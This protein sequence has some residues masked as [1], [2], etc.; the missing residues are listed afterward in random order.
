VKETKMC[1]SRCYKD[2]SNHV[3]AYA[4]SGVCDCGGFIQ[5]TPHFKALT[6]H[7]PWATLVAQGIKTIETRSWPTKYR[8]PILIHSSNQPPN[9]TKGAAPLLKKYI[10]NELPTGQLLAFTTILSC[11]QIE[12]L[13]AFL[14]NHYPY[15]LP[16]LTEKEQ[17]LGFY[18]PDRFAW[19]LSQPTPLHNPI[20]TKGALSLWHYYPTANQL[21]ELFPTLSE[22]NKSTKPILQYFK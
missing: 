13:N 17:E 12:H 21:N 14:N 4:S 1:C 7:Q 5:A 2:M 6:I 20:P 16:N 10:F 18:Q 15:T 19:I 3:P 11:V 8:G 9:K 22:H